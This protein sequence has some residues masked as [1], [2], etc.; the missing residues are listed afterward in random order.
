MTTSTPRRTVTVLLLVA[1]CGVLASGPAA[2][3]SEVRIGF[4]SSGLDG[5]DPRNGRTLHS[6]PEVFDPPDERPFGVADVFVGGQLPDGGEGI[7][8]ECTTEDRVP[9][10]LDG[11]ESAR[12][13]GLL[14]L[15]CS[16]PVGLPAR[17][18]YAAVS[19]TWRGT[20][21]VEQH[22]FD[23]G[24]CTEY[25]DVRSARLTGGMRLV[26]PGVAVGR[27]VNTDPAENSLREQRMVC[28]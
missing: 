13:A 4:A 21:A 22:V 10:R 1:T 9:A 7:V 6:S 5:T 24:D 2:A 16:S 12:A 26:V 19:M 23:H 18:G 25:M 11:L 28:S 27:L 17:S 8:Y 15:E 3:A 20:G 14:R